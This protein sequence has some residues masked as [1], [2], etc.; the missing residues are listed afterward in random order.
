MYI[1]P[2]T[3]IYSTFEEAKMFFTEYGGESLFDAENPL[4]VSDLAQGKRNLIV[5]EPGIGKTLLL[6]QIKDSLDKEG[7]TTELISLKQTHAAK[8][9]DEFLVMQA[10][11]QKALLLDALDEVRSSHFPSVLQKIEEVSAKYPELSIYLS[12]RWVFISRYPSSFSEYR[13]I[14]ISPFTREQVRTF[15][16]EAGR[17]EGDVDALLTRVM[18]FS[19]RLLVIQIPRYLSYLNEF[20]IVKGVNA[21]AQVSRNELFEHFIYSKLELEDKKLNTDKK[22]ITKRVLEKL[23]LTMEIYQSNAISKDDLMTFFDELKSDL[24]QVALSQINL[25]VFYEYSLLKIGQKNRDDIEFE[26]TEFQEY[27]AAKEITRLSDPGLAAFGFAVDPDV[28][29][30][31][32]TWFNALTFLVDMQSDLLEQLVEFSGIRTDGFKII[33]EGFLKFLSRVDPRKVPKVLRCRLFE[34][35]LAYHQRTRQWMNWDL[36]S[37]LPGFFDPTLEVLLKDWVAKAE[38]EVGAKRYVPL[39]NIA[40]VVGSLLAQETQLDRPYWRAKLLACAAD[41]NDNGVLQRNALFALGQL[42]DSTVINEI[43]DL[44]S[45]GESIMRAFLSMCTELDPENPKSLSYFFQAIRVKEFHGRYGLYAVKQPSSIKKFLETFNCDKDF[46]QNFFES[47]SIFGER[48]RKLVEHIEA[49]CDDEIAELGKEALVHS[50]HYNVAHKAEESSFILGMWDFLKKL[51]PNFILDMV[52]RIQQGSNGKVRWYYA[53]GLFAKVINK[54]DVPAFIDA[55]MAIGQRKSAFY[56]LL[57]ASGL[58]GKSEIFEAGRSKLPDEYAQLEAAQANSQNNGV[59]VSNEDLLHRFRVYLVPEAGKY[60]AEVF[61]FYNE[62]A[63]QL[64]SLLTAD[65][66][67]QLSN[68]LTASP[69]ESHL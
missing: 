22:A 5:G 2:I 9:I 42:H 69:F 25:D 60:N 35:F 34:D 15:L 57:K 44:M 3:K 67:K 41:K 36:A 10:E 54:E 28:K 38:S 53:E 24:K 49:V 11:G 8:L 19:H 21:A 33:D 64:A 59:G 46:R 32:P 1:T 55:M 27:L 6:Q 52:N 39:G 31:Y 17:S 29:E 66:R 14:A 48:D 43:P 56:V 58:R 62:Q 37:A 68:L 16:I 45:S 4:K 65:D 26:N 13:F 7:F 23:A 40:C 61:E 51:G 63:Q 20:L 12:S 18:S 30:I 50:A 47:A